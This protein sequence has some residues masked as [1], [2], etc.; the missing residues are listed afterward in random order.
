MA[1]K[2]WMN[3]DREFD[4]LTAFVLT[5]VILVRGEVSVLYMELRAQ[6]LSPGSHLGRGSQ[7]LW[8]VKVR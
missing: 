6:S 5:E 8:Q 4:V 7:G 1:A 3:S 2:D